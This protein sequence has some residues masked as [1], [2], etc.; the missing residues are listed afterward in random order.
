[1]SAYC[2][3]LWYKC[4][5]FVHILLRL[6]PFSGFLWTVNN[7]IQKCHLSSFSLVNIS[8]KSPYR[9]NFLPRTIS[10]KL[11]KN[12]LHFHLFCILIILFQG[13][14]QSIADDTKGW[15]KNIND[16]SYISIVMAGMGIPSMFFTVFTFITS[17]LVY[18]SSASMP[19]KKKRKVANS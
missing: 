13:K 6:L 7:A 18:F 19:K 15:L 10:C 1:M 11:D 12:T 17:F 16:S 4:K 2:S 3:R 8:K 14:S 9:V 5:L